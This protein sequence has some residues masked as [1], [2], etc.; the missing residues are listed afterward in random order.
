MD[1]FRT[2]APAAL[3]HGLLLAQLVMKRLLASLLRGLAP[4]TVL[5]VLL[6]AQ[7]AAP[8]GVAGAEEISSGGPS[9]GGSTGPV[10]WEVMDPPAELMESSDEW[11]ADLAG[12]WGTS[13]EDVFAISCCG[14]LIHYDGC[15]W[16]TLAPIPVVP[17]DGEW[18]LGMGLDAI[19]GTSSSDIFVIGDYSWREACV[20]H[21][22]GDAWTRQTTMGGDTTAIYGIWG[23]SPSDVFAAGFADDLGFVLHYDGVSWSASEGTDGSCLIFETRAHDVWGSSASDVFVVGNSTDSSTGAIYHFDGSEWSTIWESSASALSLEYL[24]LDGVWGSSPTDVY[25]YGWAYDAFADE[26]RQLVLHYDGDLFSPVDIGTTSALVGMWGNSAA[27]VY[28]VQANGSILHYDGIS[29]SAMS[30]GNASIHDAWGTGPEAFG[31]WSNGTILHYR[32]AV[33]PGADTGCASE[34]TM[35][36]AELTGS[37]TSLGTASSAQVCFEW[38]LTT[39][40]GQV[41]RSEK[42]TA[43]GAFSGSI[44]GLSPWTRYHYRSKVVGD[45]TAFGPDRS[46]VTPGMPG[47][48]TSLASSIGGDQAVLSGVTV[49]PEEG[50]F[51]A[52]ESGSHHCLALKADATL[53]SWGWNYFG[54]LGLGDS[55]DRTIP[56]QVGGDSNWAAVSGGGYH[57]LG[58]RSDG[59]LW[60]WGRNGS[61]QLGVGDTAE[62]HSPVRVGDDSN[63]VA[64]SAGNEHSLAVKSDGTLWAWGSNRYGQLG[65][66]RSGSAN[67]PVQVGTDS[68][69]AAVSAGDCHSLGLRSDGT[70]W[71][72][73]L[74]CYGQAAPSDFMDDKDTPVQV[75]DAS[76]WKAVSAGNCSS[77]GLRS[78][79][80]LWSWGRTVGYGPTFAQV[81]SNANWVAASAAGEHALGLQSDGSLWSWGYNYRGD[82]GLG[83]TV[84]RPDP[85]RVG[86]AGD[87]VAVSAGYQHS[88]G[89]RFDGS[90]WGWGANDFGQLGV[91][92]KGQRLVPSTRA[93]SPTVPCTVYFEWGLTPDYGNATVSQTMVSTGAS[94]AALSGLAPSTTYHFRAVVVGSDTAYGEDVAFTTD[95]PEPPPGGNPDPAG[96]NPDVSL[97]GTEPGDNQDPSLPGTQP[98]GLEGGQTAPSVPDTAPAGDAP[99]GAAPTDGGQGGSSVETIQPSGATSPKPASGLSDGSTSDG[100]TSD[101]TPARARLWL[102]PVA[103]IGGLLGLSVLGAFAAWLRAKLAA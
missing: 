3:L 94:S 23:S 57:S 97:P 67:S 8:A 93:P 1:G 7:V 24:G 9:A 83:D 92:G 88:I 21:F 59:S 77:L 47:V 12:V 11:Y 60:A 14:A 85:V 68:N 13:P 75:G 61:G 49:R 20:F 70:L 6:V 53:W 35:S 2:L 45:S 30:C 36:S 52:V 51:T 33:P 87:W 15:Q 64:V 32:G 98:D 91:G 78:D 28:A 29:W 22:D 38:G 82:L 46:F 102:C 58:L 55:T 26:Y 40:Y 16:A 48:V 84:P 50:G 74:N 86:T 71:A 72:W 27:D 96:D 90:L 99:S 34:V 5:A 44:S 10:G 76:S 42:M 19:W 17:E 73:G 43:T 103:V 62:R 18:P 39:A 80:T 56:A 41:T 79:G 4:A 54:Q 66:G 95:A 25:A 37:L 101:G 69:W 31:V 81:G 100:S 63:W 89:L 65:L